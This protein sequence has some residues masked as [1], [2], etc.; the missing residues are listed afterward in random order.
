MRTRTN[1]QRL[2]IKSLRTSETDSCFDSAYFLMACSS[3]SDN[4]SCNLFFLVAICSK[5]V[6]NYSIVQRI[7][8]WFYILHL[9]N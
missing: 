2:L 4:K 1:P 9:D 5:N 3:K 6:Y 8:I 7:T